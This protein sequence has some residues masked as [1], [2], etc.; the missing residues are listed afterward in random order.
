MQKASTKRGRPPINIDWNQFDKL[1]SIPSITRPEI[2][3]FFH[4]SDDTLNRAVKK[5]YGKPL[6]KV[7]ALK[8]SVH[9]KAAVWK[10]ALVNGSVRA[11]IFLF[12]KYAR[13]G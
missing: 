8:K 10:T 13:W 7:L 6:S 11:Q 2:T 9:I 12:K 5:Q 3:S 1:S 4:C